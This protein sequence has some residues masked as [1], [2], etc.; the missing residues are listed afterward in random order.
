MLS[1]GSQ[2]AAELG[3]EDSKSIELIEADEKEVTENN[4]IEV[5]ETKEKFH[6]GDV[7]AFGKGMLLGCC[8]AC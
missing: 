8:F 7:F 6:E 3:R 2:L 4:A 1:N 5:V